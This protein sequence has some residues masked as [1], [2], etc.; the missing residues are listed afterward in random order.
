MMRCCT[1]RDDQMFRLDR[2]A[3]K[4]AI[5]P[6]KQYSMDIIKLD[7]TFIST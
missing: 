1:V 3:A 4:R 2:H 5:V 6:R 7:C